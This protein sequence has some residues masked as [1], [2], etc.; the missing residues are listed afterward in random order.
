MIKRFDEHNETSPLKKVWYVDLGELRHLKD[1]ER[2]E[3]DNPHNNGH[4]FSW[5]V[6]DPKD[7]AYPELDTFFLDNGLSINELVI[8]HSTW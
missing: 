3:D 5:R 6:N 8:M 7:S 2:L 1:V 4:A